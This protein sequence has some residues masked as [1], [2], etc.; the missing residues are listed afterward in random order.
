[1]ATRPPRCSPET[2]SIP[3]NS[4]GLTLRK[5]LKTKKLELPFSTAQCSSS[6][7][8]PHRTGTG[9]L[10][11]RSANR[12]NGTNSRLPCR[13]SVALKHLRDCPMLSLVLNVS[14]GYAAERG[15]YRSDRKVAPLRFPPRRCSHKV[16][17][18]VI[19]NNKKMLRSAC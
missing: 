8:T 9:E 1:M 5:S 4:F 3:Q 17:N 11:V 19:S 10:I 2:E 6:S 12:K 15:I 13:G 16:C 14:S 7:C 18:T